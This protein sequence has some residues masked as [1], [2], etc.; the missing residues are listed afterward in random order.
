MLSFW[1]LASVAVALCLI[2]APSYA[3]RLALVIGN[4]TYRSV[5]GLANARNDAR[6]M[7]DTL[8]RAG[9]DTTIETDLDR[10][11]IWEALDKFKAR[12]Q[13]GDEIV[14]YFAG[15]GVQ[16]GS[17]QLMLPV[18]ITRQND[19][20]VERDGVSLVDV[21]DHFKDARFGMF[22]IDACRDNPFPKVA[23]RTLLSAKGLFPPEPVMG[24]VVILD[25]GRNQA[26]LD[27]VP[28]VNV[29]N[30]LFTHELALA[31]RQPGVEVRA[32]LELVKERV[33][34]RA[35]AANHDQRPSLVDDMRGNFYFYE[36]TTSQRPGLTA[37]DS[38]EQTWAAAQSVNSVSAYRAYLSAYPQGRFA[39]A[40]SI[41]L[42]AIKPP[43]TPVAPPAPLTP[44]TPSID[45]VELAFWEG[46]K[47]ATT[48]PEVQ[49]YLS[50]FPSGL[51]VEIARARIGAIQIAAARTSTED[52]ARE[53][54]KRVAGPLGS[55]HVRDG[56]NGVKKSSNLVE[57]KVDSDKTTYSSGDVISANGKV[58]QVRVGEVIL[59]VVEGVLWTVPPTVGSAG[60][61]KAVR[62][63]AGISI[64]GTIKWRVA[65][66][67]GK[68]R[69]DATVSYANPPARDCNGA[70]AG[71][72]SAIYEATSPIAS[73]AKT[74][75]KQ[76][77]SSCADFSDNMED[78]VLEPLTEQRV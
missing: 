25:A 54:L 65:T 75:I 60:E 41:K 44:P 3:T 48:T 10:T 64:P 63:D 76:S 70:V 9:F 61:A 12:I 66:D 68:V 21:Q 20:Q 17:T 19:K 14:F 47:N 16:L 30:G 45:P 13:K 24:Q 50:R 2:A 69:V 36:P 1:P 38:E 46:V 72:W 53:T 49:A 22:V 62:V 39:G 59:K 43:A 5:P 27:S 35:R 26:A 37:S 28:G 7:A 58:L 33:Y 57:R 55:L 18:D 73:T 29:Q 52:S 32:S 56:Y 15:H 67:A 31:L 11:R 40:A 4:D 42:E 34:E 6:L 77:S 51:F 74:R 23:G 71:T 78:S 8:K